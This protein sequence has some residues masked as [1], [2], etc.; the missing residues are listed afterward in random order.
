MP[1]YEVIMANVGQVYNSTNGFKALQEY[2]AYKR[3]SQSNYSRTSG[4]DVT[5]LRD[6]KIWYEYT[7][8][9]NRKGKQPMQDL[10]QTM[11]LAPR[12]AQVAPP[13][14]VHKNARVYPDSTCQLCGVHYGERRPDHACPVSLCLA[15]ETP[16]CLYSGLARGQC[17]LCFVGLLD[18]YTIPLCGYMGCR[19]KAIVTMP[20]VGY[21]CLKHA[22]VKGRMAYVHAT[23]EREIANWTQK[24]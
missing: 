19:A 1:T 7:G 22:V 11:T 23:H 3:L 21:A 16:Q 24:P 13:R 5:V 12:A 4:E 10:N 15:C 17:S 14:F 2:E 6:G 8:S 20:R 9:L 18:G